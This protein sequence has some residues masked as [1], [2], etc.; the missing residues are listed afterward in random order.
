MTTAFQNNAFQPDAF[1]EGAL[2]QGGGVAYSLSGAAGSYLITGKT[3]TFNVVRGLSG[4]VGSYAI[5]GQTATFKVARVL[6]GS[7]GSYAITGQTATFNTTKA[8]SGSA[9]SYGISGQSATL[10]Y[11][12]GSGTVN[13][14]LDGSAGSYSISGQSATF[15]YLA[16]KSKKDTHDGWRK[17]KERPKKSQ[18]KEDKE[19]IHRLVQEAIYGPSKPDPIIPLQTE[20]KAYT[21][22]NSVVSIQQ[23][24]IKQ[25]I[26]DDEEAIALLLMS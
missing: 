15:S 13:Y 14:T 17:I 21:P 4:A 6:S 24:A 10:T 26:D 19:D 5:S 18:I 23:S 7:A 12:P 20:E 11:T 25:Q 3:A 9:G 8:L 22:L 16:G 1:Q 2:P